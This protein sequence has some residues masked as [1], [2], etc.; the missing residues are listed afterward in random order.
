MEDSPPLWPAAWAQDGLGGQIDGPVPALEEVQAWISATL[1]N[2]PPVSGPLEIHRLKSW[3][4]T[5]RFKAGE[6]EVFFKICL[7][8]LFFGNPQIYQVLDRH[9][10]GTVPQMLAWILRQDQLWTLFHPFAGQFLYEPARFDL[11]LQAARTLAQTQAAVA[12][13]PE[14]ELAPLPRRRVADMPAMLDRVEKEIR[15]QYTAVWAAEPD[16]EDWGAH[17]HQWRPHLEAWAAELAAGQWP[18]AP[19]HVDFHSENILVDAAGRVRIVDWEETVL[20][21][22][23]FSLDRLLADAAEVEADQWTHLPPADAPEGPLGMDRCEMAVRQAYLDALPWQNPA[24]RER[25][26][27][28]ALSLAPVKYAYESVLFNG[29][30][31]R[32][33]GHPGE[34]AWY[35]RKGLERW[36]CMEK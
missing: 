10:S 28:L 12:A 20:N 26:L 5:A 35:M 6:G 27:D 24:A 13:A 21:C 32:P 23:F 14:T 18:E 36:Q 19:D 15:D 33:Q 29:S 16:E 9:C 11:M 4:L 3:G 7:L 34:T 22:P 25:G 17:L 2:Q 30:L 31:S 1:P 8:P